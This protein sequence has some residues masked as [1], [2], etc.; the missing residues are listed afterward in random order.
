MLIQESVRA[1]YRGWYMELVD[2]VPRIE[3][4][5]VYP[6]EGPGL[7]VELPPQVFEWSDL[8]IRRPEA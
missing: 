2:R 8:F 3:A 4:G 6:I 1:F 5:Y 7:G